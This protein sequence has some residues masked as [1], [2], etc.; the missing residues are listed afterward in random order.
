MSAPTIIKI[1]AENVTG[2][3][4]ALAPGEGRRREVEIG[5]TALRTWL[6]NFSALPALEAEDVDARLHVT[7]PARRI[8][9]RRAGGRLG[10]EEGDT[11]VAATVD[12]ILAQL[13]AAS[14]AGGG[15]TDEAISEV[16]APSRSRGRLQA[17]LLAGLLAILAVCWWWSLRPETPNGV[18]WIGDA[19]ERQTILAQAAGN[20]ASDNERLTLDASSAQLI[21]NNE[22]GA[23][24]L[25]TTVRVGRRGGANVLVTEAGV[26]LELIAGN[27]LRIDAI[28]Y[29]RVPAAH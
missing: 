14:F 9:V 4:R 22:A 2:E 25:R 13:M 20:Y 6:D 26:L 8:V 5:E 11:F 15:M 1:I 10:A 21:A 29:R 23:E 7:V 19:S 27:Q 24:T 28:D 12:E 16:L 18:E 17:A 3:A